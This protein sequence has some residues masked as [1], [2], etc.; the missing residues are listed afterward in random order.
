MK[1]AAAEVRIAPGKKQAS[2]KKETKSDLIGYIKDSILDLLIDCCCCANECLNWFGNSY[3][4][5]R[6]AQMPS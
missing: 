4:M 1:D 3:R 6:I 2:R 5:G